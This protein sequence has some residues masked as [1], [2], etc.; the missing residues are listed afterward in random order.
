MSIIA[1]DL[2]AKY[3]AFVKLDAEAELLEEYDSASV[4]EHEFLTYLAVNYQ[5][6][7]ADQLIVED[8]PH[9]VDY[10]GLVKRVC[11]IQ[12]R[13]A[14]RWYAMGRLHEVLYVDPATWRRKYPELRK[15]GSGME[16]VVPV[17]YEHGYAPPLLRELQGPRGGKALVSKVQTDYCAAY[18]I[19]RWALDT[20]AEHGTYD[21]PGTS[22]YGQPTMKKDR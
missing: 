2:A 18:L 11:Q 8:L 13:I 1:V 7:L 5:Y 9:G 14:E 10:R 21:V 16:A 6:D 12:G 4:G 20:F 15:R 19:C 3:S 17:A 22:R